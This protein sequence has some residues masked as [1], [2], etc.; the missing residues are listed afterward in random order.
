MKTYL[1]V[2]RGHPR[3]TTN[4]R[5]WIESWNPEDRQILSAKMNI[6]QKLA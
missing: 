6:V 5:F 3:S 4:F 2:R 1:Q